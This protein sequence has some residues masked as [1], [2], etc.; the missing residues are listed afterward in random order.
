MNKNNRIAKRLSLKTETLAKLSEK[1]L[2][3]VVGGA[4]NTY[5]G[6][7]PCIQSAPSSPE[8]GCQG[9]GPP[10]TSHTACTNGCPCRFL[11]LF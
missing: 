1:S 8:R 11:S 9:G 10:H 2:S 6:Q 3:A 5:D 4:A 7:G